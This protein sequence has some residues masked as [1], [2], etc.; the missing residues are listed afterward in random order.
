MITC[1]DLAFLHPPVS[2]NKIK[3]PLGGIF[4][5]SV[6]TSDMLTMNPVGMYSLANVLHKSGY[7]TKV[8][9]VAKVFLSERADRTIDT[10]RYVRDIDARI[11]GIG[12]HWSAHAAGAFELAR[13]IKAE[14]PDRIILFGGLTSTR[15]FDELLREHPYIDYVMLAE[16]E[17]AIIPFTEAVLT[18]G[19]PTATTPN[20][21][22]R[23]NGRIQTT[24]ISLPPLDS[25]D[26]F[27]HPELVDPKPGEFDRESL[28]PPYPI[29][30]GCLRNCRFC[31][32]SEFSYRRFFC[33]DHVSPMPIDRFR[34][35]LREMIDHGMKVLRLIGDTRTLGPEYDEALRHE[36]ATSG[37][38]F[39]TFLEL[40]SLPTYEYL[41]AWRKI[42]NQCAFTFS[43][44]SSFQELRAV[45]GKNYTNDEILELARWCEELDIKVVFCLMYAMPGHTREN[46]L[47]ELEFVEVFVERH[48]SC[49]IMY[50]PYLYLDPGCEIESDPQAY[51]FKILFQSLG[52]IAS[53]LQRSYWYYSIGYELEGLNRDDLFQS[54]LDVSLAKAKLYYSHRKLSAPNLLMTWEN[55]LLQRRVHAHIT[56][57]SGIQDQELG[58]FIYRTFPAYLRRSNTAIIQRP[59][60]GTI[61]QDKH[62]RESFIFEAFPLLYEVLFDQNLLEPE[63]FLPA[64]DEFRRRLLGGELTLDS[65]SAIEGF[66]GAI[67]GE[68]AV[69]LPF[70]SELISFE[71]TVYCY[72]YLQLG[73]L[74]IAHEVVLQ[75][76]FD[77]MDGFVEALKRDGAHLL[78]TAEPTK[79]YFTRERLESNSRFGRRHLNLFARK[80]RRLDKLIAS[81]VRSQCGRDCEQEYTSVD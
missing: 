6:G 62:E 31:G 41:E 48:P 76:C 30:R 28:A 56:L 32:G 29:I 10:W 80:N 54:I 17:H 43:P 9:N 58:D 19:D 12:L 73:E 57:N 7:R 66:F 53:S 26:Y 33:R 37:F 68:K 11:Y 52:D 44:E 39:D 23:R 40:F 20:L 77:S 78:A 35:H 70:L 21:A 2:F 36:I 45:H 16:C 69:E 61:V 18:A 55:V 72:Y 46:L 13:R 8:F 67:L 42:S 49:F 38:K 47:K 1:Y 71:W 65:A 60:I 64:A 79:Y 15:Y 14:H 75:Y 51:G 50:Q 4:D 27:A 24:P 63:E 59:H 22:F 81:L 34:Q 74:P 5:S 3:Y 25:V